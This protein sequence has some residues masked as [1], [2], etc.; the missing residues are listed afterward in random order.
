MMKKIIAAFLT[1]ILSL[2]LSADVPE[3]SNDTFRWAFSDNNWIPVYYTDPANNLGLSG[4]WP[5]LVHELFT[6]RL[7]LKFEVRRLPWAR[8]QQEVRRG[9][10]DFMLTIPTD[11]RRSYTAVSNDPVM[12][13]SMQIYTY[14]GHEKLEE[15]KR[16]E[17]AED[18]LRLELVSVTNLGNG[19]HSEN[20]EDHGIKT[21]YIQS[22]ESL[23][24]VLANKRVDILIDAPLTMNYQIKKQDLSLQIVLTDVV[25]DQSDFHLLISKKSRLIDHMDEINSALNEMI[26]DGTMAL[27]YGKYMSLE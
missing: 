3:L 18:I 1:S 7:N 26:T 11:E 25:L 10:S 19:W 24:R 15:I 17:S 14:Y 12:N 6:N 16:I 8:A 5:E 9:E 23:P 27:L 13:F 22:E 21:Y 20:I 2:T 4:F